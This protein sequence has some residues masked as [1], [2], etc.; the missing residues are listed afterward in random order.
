[1]LEDTRATI[2]K[3]LIEAAQAVLGAAGQHTVIITSSDG[4][5]GNN[6][7]TSNMTFGS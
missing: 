5:I 1:M 3:G 7:G 6:Y 2:E 4:V